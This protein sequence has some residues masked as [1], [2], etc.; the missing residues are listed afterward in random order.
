MKK[1]LVALF[2]LI[3]VGLLPTFS[4]SKSAKNEFE[5]YLFAYFEGKG[6]GTEQ[7]QLRFAISPNATN[8]V[9]LNNNQPIL[10]SDKISQTGGI[11]DPH[12][13]HCDVEIGQSARLET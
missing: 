9:A 12:I 6:K 1:Y 2:F 10:S 7:E 8:W 3:I 11:R 13:L 5:A 4:Q